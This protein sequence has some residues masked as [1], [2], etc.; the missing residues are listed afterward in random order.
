MEFR[1]KLN[2]LFLLKIIAATKTDCQLFPFPH[3][4][5][6]EIVV[7]HDQSNYVPQSRSQY[8]TP[9]RISNLFEFHSDAVVDQMTDELVSDFSDQL[10]IINRV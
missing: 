8:L 5:N 10:V 4:G 3:F 2:Y 9:G 6:T 1:S 7:V